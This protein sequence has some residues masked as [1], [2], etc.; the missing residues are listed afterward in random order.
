V[1]HCTAVNITMC[2]PRDSEGGKNR[3]HQSSQPL[4]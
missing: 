2:A 4:L 1:L 3:R